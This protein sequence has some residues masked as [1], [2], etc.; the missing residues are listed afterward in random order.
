[1]RG[2]SNTPYNMCIVPLHDVCHVD[3][4]GGCVH[5]VGLTSQVH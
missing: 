4:A 5:V 2:A 1:M 3:T